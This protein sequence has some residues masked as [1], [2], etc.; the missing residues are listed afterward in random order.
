MQPRETYKIVAEQ[1]LKGSKASGPWIADAGVAS[2]GCGADMSAPS[3]EFLH[4]FWVLLSK[5]KSSKSYIL[6]WSFSHVLS[7]GFFTG[8][9]SE[10]HVHKNGKWYTRDQRLDLN[11]ST[12]N[13]PGLYI[14]N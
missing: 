8:Q 3:A 13:C 6:S 14:L 12:L 1:I 2:G 5:R 9:K 11:N 4:D 10:C 7:K